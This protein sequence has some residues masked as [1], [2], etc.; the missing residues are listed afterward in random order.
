M[1]AP[2]SKEVAINKLHNL[3]NVKFINS[4]ALYQQTCLQQSQL[5][6]SSWCQALLFKLHNDIR[7]RVLKSR[8][9]TILNK[10]F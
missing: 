6:N 4:Q 2:I 9:L 3:Q 1:I 7:I 8:E 5:N 10:Q